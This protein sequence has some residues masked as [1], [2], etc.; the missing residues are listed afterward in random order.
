MKFSI[1]TSFYRRS[2]LVEGVYQ[3]ILEQTHGDWE[4][5]VTDDFSDYNNAREILLD[6]CRKDHRVKYYEQSRKKECFYNPHKGCSGD[7][8]VQFDSD[9]F[10]YPRLLEL[11]NQVFLK[12]PE[13]AG[14]SCFS[15]TVDDQGNW[16]EIQGG[17]SYNVGETPA[18]NFTPMGRAWK[19]I[20]EE[21]DNGEMQW[22]QN[23]TNI[24]RYVE[25][26]GK[27]MYL[28][29]TLYRYYYSTDTF[30]RELGRTEEQYASIENERF[31]IEGKFPW[32][33]HPEKT[34]QSLYY[35]PIHRVARAFAN[36]DF[37]LAKTRQKILFYKSEIKVWEKQLLKELFWDHDL[38]FDLDLDVVFDEII[39]LMD[40]SLSEQLPQ[41]RERLS[42]FNKGTLLKLN[43]DTREADLD[44]LFTQMNQ[45]FEGYGWVS[46]G[47]EIYL[48]TAI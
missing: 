23:D 42:V 46:G 35:L 12:H 31:F 19:N 26:R 29:R 43:L 8:I 18:F 9:D 22:Y 4:W 38:Y 2:H 40:N 15:Q 16:V 28:P 20:I 21:F 11:Y 1:S 10:A 17:G 27:W 39:L 45:T 30:S 37:N 47:Y 14:I 44:L 34:T 3:Q 13:I 7:I 25:T 33:Q 24:V 48:N 36:A 32:L 6:I 5:I 41:L